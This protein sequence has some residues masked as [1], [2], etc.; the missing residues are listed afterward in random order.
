[1]K[2]NEKERAMNL[3]HIDLLNSAVLVIDVQNDYFHEEGAMGRM[4]LH[5]SE[6]ANDIFTAQKVVP[7]L[8][9]FVTGARQLGRPII[10]V[11]S[12]Y[13]RWTDS[14]VFK[15][16]HLATG[17]DFTQQVRPGTWGAEFYRIA[18]RPE[19]CIV[20]KYRH[21]AFIDT[22]LD[23]ILRSIGISTIVLTGIATN[24]CV[25]STARDGFMKDYY[26]VLIDDCCAAWSVKEHES[27]L[28]NVRTAFGVVARSEELLRSWR[29]AKEV[30]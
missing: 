19:D 11:R 20:T 10:F 6:G 2:I 24:I 29:V 8:E 18:P 12:E 4:H 21:S 27:A 16:R 9:S 15:T 7:R 3:E 30:Q 14:R 5:A 17:V 22:N 23:L 1:M 13:S 28:F 25:E 26:V